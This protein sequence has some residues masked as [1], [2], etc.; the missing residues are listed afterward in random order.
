MLRTSL[1]RTHTANIIMSAYVIRM[2][3]AVSAHTPRVQVSVRS[4]SASGRSKLG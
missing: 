3:L 4:V 1:Q 2:P